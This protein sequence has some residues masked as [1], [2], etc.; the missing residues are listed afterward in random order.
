VIDPRRRSRWRLADAVAGLRRVPGRGTSEHDEGLERSVLVNEAAAPYLE[1]AGPAPLAEGA[2]IVQRHHPEG[3]DEVLSLFAMLKLPSGRWEFTV[4]DPALRVAA[5][6][7]AACGQCHAQA[8]FDG[9]FGP[10]LSASPEPPASP[11][12]APTSA[13]PR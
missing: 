12:E 2:L 5:T 8:P 10:P 7:H 3:S 13:I 9:L 6:P 4:L 1:L 11:D